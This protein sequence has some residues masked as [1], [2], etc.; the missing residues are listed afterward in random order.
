MRPRMLVAM[1]EE[2]GAV[3]THAGRR[4]AP[5]QGR[6]CGSHQGG[7]YRGLWELLQPRKGAR[8]HRRWRTM[9]P[10]LGVSRFLATVAG[11][12]GARWMSWGSGACG[13][14]CTVVSFARGLS[15]CK[16]EEI[17]PRGYWLVACKEKGMMR[18]G[19]GLKFRLE[20]GF[21]WRDYIEDDI[22]LLLGIGW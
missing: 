16:G 2:L 5:V 4:C 8:L 18:L 20:L 1:R 14:A 22:G 7:F 19:I 21:R 6:E 10:G 13:N 3:R 15:K 11:G 12:E 9:W 17:R